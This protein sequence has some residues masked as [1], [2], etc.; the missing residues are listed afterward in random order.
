MV[1]NCTGYKNILYF[2]IIIQKGTV[3]GVMIY[4]EL[5]IYELFAFHTSL[6]YMIHAILSRVCREKP[7]SSAVFFSLNAL[8]LS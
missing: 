7:E 4:N 3:Y 2:D 6:A 8:G 1:S 5:Y